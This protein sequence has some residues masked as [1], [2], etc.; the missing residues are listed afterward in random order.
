MSVPVVERKAVLNPPIELRV[1][2]TP[3]RASADNFI[4]KDLRPAGA[5]AS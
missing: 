5:H 4:A 1:A 2:G 3:T